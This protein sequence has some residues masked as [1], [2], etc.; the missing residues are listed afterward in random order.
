LTMGALDLDATSPLFAL[1]S[2][3]PPAPYRDRFEDSSSPLITH[4]ASPLFTRTRTWAVSAAVLTDVSGSF[5]F[6]W[7]PR[8][9]SPPLLSELEA[10]FFS[11]LSPAKI[12][13]GPRA[14]APPSSSHTEQ[15]TPLLIRDRFRASPSFRRPF[16]QTRWR[17]PRLRPL[18]SPLC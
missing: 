13:G 15:G 9:T 5:L 7:S 12:V 14:I 11:T 2:V 16:F 10:F 3:R 8:T 18:S 1:A 17:P 6:S 4:S